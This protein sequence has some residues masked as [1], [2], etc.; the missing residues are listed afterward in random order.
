MLTETNR[1]ITKG[2]YYIPQ[3]S[4]AISLVNAHYR[5]KVLKKVQLAYVWG[6]GPLRGRDA[7]PGIWPIFRGFLGD[8]R[9]FS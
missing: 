3:I 6:G 4:R 8:P 5:A 9:V 7:W 2:S 1:Q